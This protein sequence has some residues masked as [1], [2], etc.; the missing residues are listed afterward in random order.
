[1]ATG[2]Y[3]VIKNVLSEPQRISLINEVLHSEF[4]GES[5]LGKEF[6][7]TKGF[8]L[9]FKRSALNDICQS[10]PYLSVLLSKVLFEKCNAFYINPLVLYGKSKVEAHI[11]CRL[12]MPQNIRIIP[13]LVSVY[14]AD[15][16]STM[17]GGT[18]VLNSGADNE[19]AILPKTD[20]LI[21][22]LGN[23]IHHVETVE[24]PQRRISIV[25]EQ[26]NL[27]DELI[28]EFPY[29]DVI[30]GSSRLQRLN[31]LAS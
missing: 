29:C 19:I 31:A 20:D 16:S 30:I 5:A 24:T 23:V 15:V 12:A 18:L 27:D 25:C 28:S 6:I 13:N 22:F 10:L 4:F 11:D 7:S 26:Y 3:T 2:F 1:M 21:H 9:V 17:K 8:S 14:Y